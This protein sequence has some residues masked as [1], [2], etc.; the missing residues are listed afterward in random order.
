MKS[1]FSSV[2]F[3]EKLMLTKHLAI[4]IKSGVPIYDAF[5][6]LASHTPS[7][8]FRKVLQGILKDIESGKSLYSALSKYP[9]V[10]DNFYT[11]LVKVSEE[12]GTLE[13]NLDFLS[14]QLSK[15]YALRKKI[16]GAMFYPA[17]IFVASIGIGGYMSLVILPQ[18]V[19]F[20]STL[21]IELPLTTKIMLW[22]A[23]LMKMHGVLIIGVGLA[24]LVLMK[25]LFSLKFFK[26]VWHGALVRIPLFG[27]I[28]LYGQLARFS[29]NLGTLLKSG[30]PV[31]VALRT[32]SDT[33]SNVVFQKHLYLITEDLIK[34]KSI[35]DAMDKRHYYE[36]PPIINKMI[37]IGE[38]TGNLE[39]VLLYLSDFFEEE[40][41][42]ITK[43]L[44]TVLEPLMLA[45]IGL[46]VA[47]MAMAIISPIYKLTGSIR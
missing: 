31:D 1:I 26:P 33:L 5:E 12:S 25:I 9:N 38:E 23:N 19:D 47:F 32:T 29:R 3:V 7:R 20:F 21:D 16:Q 39:E 6:T 41:D 43:N 8:Y 35:S 34:G 11:N 40:V 44:T 18:L 37:K 42:N 4:M 45:V 46:G 14:K 13:E 17:M 36:F 24:F 30:V 27:K 22:F 10:F 28:V 2:S 15:D